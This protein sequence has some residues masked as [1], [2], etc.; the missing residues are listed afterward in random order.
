MLCLTASLDCVCCTS[1]HTG[2]STPCKV[3]VSIEMVATPCE[4]NHFICSTI[5]LKL[6]MCRYDGHTM[7]TRWP[8]HKCPFEMN[9][10]THIVHPAT[11]YILR[12]PWAQLKQQKYAGSQENLVSLSEENWNTS[13]KRTVCVKLNFKLV[14]Y[15]LYL[16]TKLCET[17]HSSWEC[18]YPLITSP[19]R[20]PI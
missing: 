19:S 17:V 5:R 8:L 15:F 18:L 12:T 7:A 3:V 6:Y 1:M 9:T 13:V 10:S 20:L 16:S 14:H 2:V 11:S 4:R